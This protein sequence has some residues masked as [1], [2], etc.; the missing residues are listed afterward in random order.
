M[1]AAP[2]SGSPVSVA[3]RALG[4]QRTVVPAADRF[5]ALHLRIS[6]LARSGIKFVAHSGWQRH[7]EPRPSSN[8]QC[9]GKTNYSVK[10]TVLPFHWEPN[11]EAVDAFGAVLRARRLQAALTQEQLALEADIRRTYVSM[12]ELGQH[13]PTLNMLFTLAKALHCE[14]SDLLLEVEQRLASALRKE[15]RAHGK[16]PPRSVP[17]A[18]RGTK[19]TAAATAASGMHGGP[20]KTTARR[21]TD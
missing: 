19:Q 1:R 10:R 9:T 17:P 8:S 14:P 15:K 13:Q 18:K 4:V 21:R 2:T 3:P 16:Q 20:G 6:A 5:N 11:L 7:S 12:L